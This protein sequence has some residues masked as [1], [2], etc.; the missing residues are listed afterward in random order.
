MAT[1]RRGDSVT[2]FAVGLVVFVVLFVIALVA[3]ILAYTQIDTAQKTAAQASSDLAR[4]IKPGERSDPD[5]DALY[6]TAGNNSV[7]GLLNAENRELKRLISGD[8]RQSLEG[9]RMDIR[10][11]GINP[12][13]A[14][15]IGELR[16]VLAEKKA[17]EE[18][19]AKALADRDGLSKRFVQLEDAKKVSDQKLADA[20]KQLRGQFDGLRD[21]QTK[22]ESTSAGER[23]KLEQR[24]GDVQGKLQKELTDANAQVEQLKQDATV[25]RQRLADIM[26][27]R[28]NVTGGPD[29]AT[30]PDGE[31]IGVSSDQRVVYI[32]IGRKQRVTLGLTFN[33]YERAGAIEKEADGELK[34]GK[35]IIEITSIA[36][37][38][39]TGRVI[40]MTRNTSLSEGD[41]IANLVYDPNQ[42]Y[43]FHVFGRFDLDRTGQPNDSDRKRLEQMILQWGG[44]LQESLSYDTDF[45]VIGAEPARPEPLRSDVR[46][47]RLIEE[48]AV[49]Q[50]VWED[51][52]RLLQEANRYQTRVLNTNRFLNLVGYYQR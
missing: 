45:L 32:N 49:K 8:P 11:A 29:P 51:Y 28:S 23:K 46:D 48:F 12:E 10:Q 26:A 6:N 2:G 20:E 17:M 13:S 40:Q 41:M 27:V 15:L 44:T 34:T 4:W 39:A 1:T 3:A 42:N 50:R 30:M 31:V 43:K 22:Y 16:R 47:P 38:T 25:L 35:A 18:R 36:D 37:N 19:A 9:L 33:V 5:I 24:L 21:Q 14:A 52:Q 7:A